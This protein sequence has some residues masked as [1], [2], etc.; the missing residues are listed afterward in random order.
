MTPDNDIG[1]HR[2]QLRSTSATRVR[3]WPS[4]RTQNA[5]CPHRSACT[6]RPIAD[7]HARLIPKLG[8]MGS[9]LPRALMSC[10]C[11]YIH[12]A[13]PTDQSDLLATCLATSSRL[14]KT[15]RHRQAGLCTFAADRSLLRV[16]SHIDQFAALT[17]WFTLNG[18]HC[19]S[20]RSQLTTNC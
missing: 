3:L 18:L 8:P 14:M 6:C 2:S 9:R 7:K 10:I 17:K 16:A 15:N 12:G 5:S 19:S 13:V 1:R 20:N 4:E 11:I